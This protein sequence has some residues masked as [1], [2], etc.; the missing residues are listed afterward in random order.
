MTWF[1]NALVYR[2]TQPVPAFAGKG[3]LGSEN[4][5]ALAELNS[6]L[7][8]KAWR[9]PAPSELT[10]YGWKPPY[11][12]RVMTMADREDPSLLDDLEPEIPQYVRSINNGQFLLI[13]ASHIK[14]LVPGNAIKRLVSTR[15]KAIETTEMRVVYKKERDALK[16]DVIAAMLPTALVTEAITF[17]AIDTQEGLII[18]NTS[19][20][21]TAEALLST[22]REC[23]GSLPVRPIATQLAPEISMTSWL[24]EQKAPE[25]FHLLDA[26]L[27][28]DG[29]AQAGKVAMV[30]QDMDAEEVTMT[31]ATGKQAT[32][33]ALA[34]K[35]EV[36]FML[37][38]KLTLTKLAFSDN[39]KETALSESED[40]HG[41]LDANIY[42]MMQTFREW[43]PALLD[44][45]GGELTPTGI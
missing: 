34:Y 30:R 5:L 45:L 25:D 12:D 39:M 23:L 37:D 35:D 18:I 11:P 16:D 38:R 10:T 36:A 8:A 44:A 19:S 21:K 28:E 1:R 43:V 4:H 9:E 32:K 33:L 24:K 29:E 6:Q 26:V 42:L 14:R 31:L 22:L 15:I 40:P 3:L 41:Q 13:C 27:L 20:A 2:L 7:H 17:A